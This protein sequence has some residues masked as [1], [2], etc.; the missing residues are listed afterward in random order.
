M[1]PNFKFSLRPGDGLLTAGVGGP[2]ARWQ[3]VALSKGILKSQ[4][5][6]ITGFIPQRSHAELITGAS[7]QTFGIR[8]RTRCRD[9]G[10]ADYIG[11][12]VTLARLV[13]PLSDSE[14]AS[15]WQAAKMGELMGRLAR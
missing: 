6:K 11:A 12:A 8:W 7:G 14:M 3:D 5:R 2:A 4:A 9:N 1:V 13:E 15:A 10:L